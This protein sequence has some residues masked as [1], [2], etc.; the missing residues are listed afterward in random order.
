MKKKLYRTENLKLTK[1]K[2][3]YKLL[4]EKSKYF[5]TLEKK[6]NESYNIIENQKLTTIKNNLIRA[7]RFARDY[8]IFSKNKFKL[9]PIQIKPKKYHYTPDVKSL[10]LSPEEAND[11]NRYKKKDVDIDQFSLIYKEKNSYCFIPSKPLKMSNKFKLKLSER[12]KINRNITSFEKCFDNFENKKSYRPSTITNIFTS[13]DNIKNSKYIISNINKN[14]SSFLY[15]TGNYS[16]FNT[17][18]TIK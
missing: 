6:K 18:K 11:P 16:T 10:I 14:C 2:D 4:F 9:K 8:T 3:L 1:Y 12:K 15:N 7:N 13:Q 17:T 5:K